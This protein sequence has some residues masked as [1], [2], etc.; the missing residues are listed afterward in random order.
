MAK[1]SRSKNA[2]VRPDIHSYNEYRV[3]LRDWFAF[4]KSEDPGFSLRTLSLKMGM[5]SGFMS[6]VLSG[7]R[8]LTL[9][10]MNKF[11]QHS[12]L[13]RAEKI[14]F[15]ALRNLEEASTQKQKLAA[16]QAVQRFRGYQQSRPNESLTYKYLTKWYYVAIREMALQDEFKLDPEWI[17]ERL[18]FKVSLQEVRSALDFL[19]E[20]GYVQVDGSGRVTA[21]EKQID[22]FGDIYR[23]S[24]TEFYRQ[25][26][27]LAHDSIAAVPSAERTILGHTFCIT[28]DQFQEVQKLL[29]EFQK[30][31]ADLGQ[32]GQKGTRVY[33][34]GLQAFPLSVSPD[35][36]KKDT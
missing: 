36:I 23:I 30:K 29:L 18:L 12:K 31:I 20:N 4:L 14:F 15:R 35:K 33:Q 10:A 21:P 28:D 13:D 27:S 9:E 24:L 11:L 8:G 7:E 22:C 3:F 32:A 2:Q 25:M 16:F 1:S 19:R 26:F 17:R 5:G 34:I 6:L